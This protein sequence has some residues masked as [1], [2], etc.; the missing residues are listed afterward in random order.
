MVKISNYKMS[1][2][3]FWNDWTDEAHDY[4]LVIKPTD[5]NL[6]MIHAIISGSGRE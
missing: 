3:I 2:G 1:R 5:S 6:G 4:S